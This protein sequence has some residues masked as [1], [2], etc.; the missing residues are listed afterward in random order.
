ML[1]KNYKIIKALLFVITLLTMQ[2]SYAN[3][4]DG[5]LA[6]SKGDYATALKE[7][8]PLAAQGEALAQFGMGLMYKNGRGVPQNDQQAA[9]WYRKA[10][11]QGIPPAQN[12][13]ALMYASGEG[14]AQDYQQAA[15]WFHK[16]A[17]KNIAQAQYSLG[18]LYIN[19]EGVTQ[20]Y[21]Q[22]D[23]WLKKA[24]KQGYAAAQSE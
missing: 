18:M 20:D 10:A 14:I 3:I 24:D 1:I 7:L 15:D 16:A 23:E 5:F 2:P 11:E 8:E 13:L 21:K 6:Y 17:D 19:G 12:N 22:A 9:D 4:T